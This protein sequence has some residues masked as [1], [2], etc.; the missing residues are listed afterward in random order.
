MKYFPEM[1]GFGKGGASSYC[2]ELTLGGKAA[3]RLEHLAG[4]ISV[5][6]LLELVRQKLALSERHHIKLFVKGGREVGKPGEIL[7]DLKTLKGGNAVNKILVVASLPQPEATV[8]DQSGDAQLGE[9]EKQL[10]D[11]EGRFADFDETLDTVSQKKHLLYFNCVVNILTKI[12]LLKE[13]SRAE[14]DRNERGRTI[15]KRANSLLDRVEAKKA[16]LGT[17]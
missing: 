11:A 1:F 14:Y 4:S 15:I 17:K 10:S 13:T 5:Q 6:E 9:L 2:V 3:G 16:K 12:D 8:V 7:Q